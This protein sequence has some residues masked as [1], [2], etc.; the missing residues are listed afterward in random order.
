MPA[1]DH[2]RLARFLADP[3]RPA[4]TLRYHELQGFLFAVASAPEVI[5]PSEWLPRI[6]G[7][8]GDGEAYQ[9]AH[10]M[11]G[12][13]HGPLP[14]RITDHGPRSTGGAP[15]E[16]ARCGRIVHR[17]LHG[18]CP[19]SPVGT[20][21]LPGTTG[22]STPSGRRPSRRTL[23]RGVRLGRDD[24]DQFFSLPRDGGGVPSRGSPRPVSPSR[25]R[26]PGS[27]GCCPQR[28]PITRAW[29]ARV[30]RRACRA[31]RR[32]CRS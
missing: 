24:L 18:R 16:T 29:V 11:I 32:G 2:P 3:A 17:Q 8:A 4:H 10:A 5:P 20:G 21:L 26:R 12:P 30:S 1:V 19:D 15:H 28:S 7:E 22:G 27:T 6:F 14:L 13:D 9:L 31:R 25:G 23:E